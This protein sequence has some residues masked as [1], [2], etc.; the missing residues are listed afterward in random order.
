MTFVQAL[1]AVR[2][3]WWIPLLIVIVAVVAVYTLKPVSTRQK[4]QY[5]ASTIQIVN[6]TANQSSTVNLPEAQLEV[7]VGVVPET[8]ARILHYHGDPVALAAIPQVSINPTVGTLIISVSGPNGNED[9]KIANAFANALNL[10]M[11]QSAVNA[12]QSQI[13]AIQNHLNSLQ[14][15]ISAN[16]SQTDPVSQAKVGGLEDQYRVAF[17]QF[18][19]LAAQGQPQSTFTFLQHAAP[20]RSGGSGI[21]RSRLAQVLIAGIVGLLIG[22]AVVILLEL[23]RPRIR[24]RVDAERDFG[25]SVLAEVPR[26]SRKQRQR[27]AQ[28]GVDDYRLGAYRESYRMLR[29]AILLQGAADPNRLHVPAVDAGP[30]LVSGPQV[31]LVTSGVSGEGKSTTVAN[32]AVAM[33]ESGREVLICDADFRAPTVHLAFGLDAGPGLTD[34]ITDP[35]L[36]GNLADLVHPTSVPGVS[37]ICG[38]SSVENAAEL[39]ATKGARLLEQ[40]R[41][42]ADVVIMDTAPLL[43]VSDAS[44]MLPEVDAVVIVARAHR[45][46]RESA[47]RT[48]ELL[49]RAEIPVLGVVLV[50]TESPGV[51]EYGRQYGYGYGYGY[52]R[53][54]AKP[55]WRHRLF[56]RRRH[57]DVVRVDA[58]RTPV[59]STGPRHAGPEDPEPEELEVLDTQEGDGRADGGEVAVGARDGGTGDRDSAQEPGQD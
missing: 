19:Q 5:V 58:G 25:C 41:S 21:P 53:R 54:H 40:A 38:G 44:E 37:L 13:D 20:V 12:Y 33:S 51:A 47:R 27:F 14:S 4:P 45:T 17:D 9:A 36:S 49:D 31:I 59:A 32:L 16:E 6:P 48:F 10:K 30:H 56:F 26:L 1:Q 2:R 43:V 55:S 34:L 57:G 42:L 28:V 39:V 11:T 52:G 24:D 8:A 23:L 22:I 18:Q 46:T 50:G 15:Q 3:R 29:T 35:S 7:K